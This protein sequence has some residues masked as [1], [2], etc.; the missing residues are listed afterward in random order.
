MWKMHLSSNRM[1]EVQQYER[2]AY[3]GRIAHGPL[4]HCVQYLKNWI[5]NFSFTY[6][7]YTFLKIER[8]NGSSK[9]LTHIGRIAVG[10]LKHCLQWKW[11]HNT[12]YREIYIFYI[13]TSFTYIY[14]HI[15]THIC[16]HMRLNVYIYIM[17]SYITI[18]P[19]EYFHFENIRIKNCMPYNCTLTPRPAYPWKCKVY[20]RKLLVPRPEVVYV[21][22]EFYV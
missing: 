15:Y 21:L 14:L 11:E 9:K 2:L 16:K 19:L 13:Y 6:I 10:S 1:N 5:L 8:V 17:K 7:K 20:C 22:R 3:I 18:A 12:R 4:Y